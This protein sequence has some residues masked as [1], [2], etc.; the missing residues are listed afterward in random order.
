MG[1]G[2]RMGL[3]QPRGP[4]PPAHSACLPDLGLP[5]CP[6]HLRDLYQPLRVQMRN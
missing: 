1:G 5:L 3:A 6:P 2:W 4:G